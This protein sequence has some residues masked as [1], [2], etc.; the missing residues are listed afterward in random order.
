MDD[1]TLEALRAQLIDERAELENLLQAAA[2]AASTVTLDQTRTG[3]LSRMDALQGQQVA[4]DAQRR[5]QQQLRE[6]HAALVRMDDGDYGC[7]EACGDD[8]AIG[9]LRISPAARRC[10]TCAD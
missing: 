1:E 7:C 9:R 5:R 4:Q 2:D 8:I 10:V 6:V 3:R